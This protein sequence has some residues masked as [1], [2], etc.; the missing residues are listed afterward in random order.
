MFANRLKNY[1]SLSAFLLCTGMAFAQNLPPRVPPEF[2]PDATNK[3]NQLIDVNVAPYPAS[4][5]SIEQLVKDVLITGNNNCGSQTVS[6]VVVYPNSAITDVKRPWGYFNKGTAPFPFAEGIVLSTGYAKSAGNVS[7]SNSDNLSTTYGNSSGDQDLATAIGVNNS[8]L[9]D[10]VYIEFDFVPSSTQMKFNYIFASEEYTGYFPCSYTDGFALLLKKIG[11]PNYTNLAVLPG[12]GGPVSV[13]N[14]RPYIHATCQAVNETY[15]A[16]YNTANVGTNFNGRTVPLTAMATVIPG[17]TYHIKMVLADYNDNSYDSAVFLEAGSFD[18]GVQI[19][20]PAGVTLPSNIDVCDNS[21]QI[22]VASVQATSATYQWFIGT[23]PIPGA[24]NASYTPTESGTYTVEVTIP[25]NTCPGI[26]SVTVNWLS[27]P[28]VQNASLTECY[29]TGSATFNLTA[30]QPLI[31]TLPN[32]ALTYSYYVNLADAQAGNTNVIAIPTA[33]QSTGQ[34]VYVRVKNGICAKVAELQLIVAPQLGVN[35]AVPQ[36]ITCSVPEIILDA[37]ASIYPAGST[38]SWTATGGGNIL[39]GANTLTPLVNEAG[40]YTLTISNTYQPNNKTCS[41]SASVTVIKDVTPPVISIIATQMTI[42]EG[43]SVMLT[44]SGAATYSWTN[45]P[46]TGNIQTVSPTSATTYTVTGTG[47][48]GCLATA[49][50][51][52]TIDVVPAIVSTL[53]GGQICPGDQ[54]LLDAGSGPNYTYLWNTGETT[55]TITTGVPGTYT[56]TIDNGVCTRQFSTDVIQAQIPQIINADFQNN[57]LT[58]TASNPS[59]GNLEYSIDGGMT[60]QSSNIFYNVSNNVTLDMRVRVKFTSCESNLAYFTFYMQNHITPNGDGINDVIDLS[61]LS[62]Y[63]N[64]GGS[65]FDRYGKIIFKANKTNTI[66]DGTFQG[67]RLP[68]ATY[69]YQLHWEDPANK[70]NVQKN[71]WI[72]LKN[73]D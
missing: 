57:T 26:A 31:T 64:F 63:N 27:S 43:D 18:I 32:T 25:G 58:L 46:G 11:D 42:C 69:W 22:L 54:I 45:L 62:I 5:Y 41:N 6:N 44:A 28:I 8:N 65:V 17:E 71:G 72:L 29:T 16:G 55:Q 73:R 33:F 19:Q 66:W 38:F 40:T 24:T 50:A 13:T 35:I 51:T 48:N 20:T 1:F 2:V 53:A 9:R 70:S 23:N 39:S 47:A 68:T 59:N 49:P 7:A 4:N 67:R 30:A 15:F 10:P 61:G 12:G 21:P 14:I 3:A 56:V 37:S 36:N 60:W 34:T 52:I